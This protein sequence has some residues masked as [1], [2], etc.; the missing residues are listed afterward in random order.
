MIEAPPR[1]ALLGYYICDDC[2][3]N[4]RNISLQAQAYTLLK[5]LD[6]YH[7]TIG[8]VNCGN[9]WMFTDSAPSVLPSQTS[10]TQRA[11][12]QAQQ[13]ALQLSLDVVMQENYGVSLEGHAADGSWAGGV[14]SDGFFRHGAA[15]EVVMNC[16]SPNVGRWG[17]RPLMRSAAWLGTLTA[18]MASN[19]VFIYTEEMAGPRWADAA[20]VAYYA[21]QLGALRP[22]ISAPFASV[23]HPRVASVSPSAVRARAWALPPSANR[24]EC[25][26]FVVA[27][28]TV[29]DQPS[30]VSCTPPT[31]S[32]LC[33]V[34]RMHSPP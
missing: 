30:Q 6:P 21:E 28:N 32:A 23:E 27:V 15:F 25:V 18:G 34:L 24:T 20:Q 19:L 8:A 17:A 31:Q 33:G 22:A 2:C 16:P 7:V 13:P 29:E 4:A 5:D 26:A 12:P 3:S 11:L 9:S 14:G 10:I 1:S